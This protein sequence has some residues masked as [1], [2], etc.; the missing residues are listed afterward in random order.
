MVALATAHASPRLG[1]Q[2]LARESSVVGVT[3]CTF[4]FP[5]GRDVWHIVFFVFLALQKFSPSLGGEEGFK[6][7]NLRKRNTLSAVSPPIRA[8]VDIYQPRRSVCHS[9][10]IACDVSCPE[11]CYGAYL[12]SPFTHI[13]DSASL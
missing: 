13:Y 7:R 6:H 12:G 11:R 5:L 10:L 2:V 8:F 1:A 3:V 4:Y 9:M